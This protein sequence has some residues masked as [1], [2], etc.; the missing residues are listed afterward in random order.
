MILKFL[1]VVIIA[2]FPVLLQSQTNDKNSILLQWKLQPKEVISYKTIMDMMDT[3]ATKTP[4]DSAEKIVSF[5]KDTLNKAGT[6]LKKLLSE[7]Q[8][9]SKDMNVTTKLSKN[10]KGF[11]DLE[12]TG[13]VKERVETT[14]KEAKDTLTSP[15]EKKIVAMKEDVMV[16]GAINENGTIQ[17]F[18]V[19]NDQKNLISLFFELPNKPIKIGDSWSLDIHFIS[20]N[21][22][23]KCDTSFKNNNITLVDI[24]KN[25]GE[26]IA[27]IKYDIIELVAGDFYNRFNFGEK[28]KKIFIK[29]TFK[30][31]GEFS[32][33]KGRWIS[34]DGVKSTKSVG[35]IGGNYVRK[36]SLIPY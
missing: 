30:G 36:F 22:S 25:G 4:L 12:M 8:E 31:I 27:V 2:L 19:E 32:V 11:I 24:K 3:S 1:Y 17:S 20:L 28:L 26:T 34:F 23:F 16:R 7:A 14:K 18:Y 33:D 6:F 9:L 35:H 21:E 10:E 5:P 29:T 13:K 15:Q